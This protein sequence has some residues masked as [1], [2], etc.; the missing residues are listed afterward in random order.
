MNKIKVNNKPVTVPDNATAKQVKNA[1]LKV[2][3]VPVKKGAGGAI[4]LRAYLP[5][6]GAL[7]IADTVR[8]ER[9]KDGKWTYNTK[10]FGF[11][12]VEFSNRIGSGRE[13]YWPAS[14]GRLN[15]KQIRAAAIEGSTWGRRVWKRQIVFKAPDMFRGKGF[16]VSWTIGQSSDIIQNAPGKQFDNGY[17]LST[18]DG[19][20]LI[21]LMIDEAESRR[22]A[23]DYS[24]PKQTTPRPA[25]QQSSGPSDTRTIKLVLLRKNGA[26][27]QVDITKTLTPYGLSK[28]VVIHRDPKKLRV[29]W[30]ADTVSSTAKLLYRVKGVTIDLDRHPSGRYYEG[31]PTVVQWKKLGVL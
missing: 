11:T 19:R 22:Q 25:F 26:F 24:R 15:D 5:S 2:G 17:T 7:L 9:I 13:G 27:Q 30:H 10:S 4:E 31:E 12:D 20:R 14:A 1:A 6:G 16:K 28:L 23:W 18:R 21:Q 3:I 29:F 8:I